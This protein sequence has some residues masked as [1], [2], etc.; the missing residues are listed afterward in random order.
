MI[1][2]VSSCVGGTGGVNV[3]Y[4][5]EVS[6][7]NVSMSNGVHLTA[8]HSSGTDGRLASSRA[9]FLTRASSLMPPQHARSVFQSTRSSFLMGYPFA[10]LSLNAETTLNKYTGNGG[11]ML[12]SSS[13]K[14]SRS[15]NIS[16]RW[17]IMPRYTEISVVTSS[18]KSAFSVGVIWKCAVSA[19]DS[20]QSRSCF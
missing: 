17:Y 5:T 1:G 7:R 18:R 12:I 8:I 15:L 6:C 19:S 3:G 14:S 16:M 20:E 13:A 2:G 11:S 4:F 9:N 10:L